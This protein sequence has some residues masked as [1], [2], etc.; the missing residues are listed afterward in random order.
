MKKKRKLKTK[1]LLIFITCIIFIT[2]SICYGMSL[3]NNTKKQKKVNKTKENIKLNKL[4]NIDQ[5]IDYF[6]YDYIDRYIAYQ[7]ENKD[8][9]I[10]QIITEVNIGLD[11]PYYTNTKKAK[12]LN[13][14]QILVNKYNYLTEDYIP[15]NLE[16]IN[17]E[18]S[19]S[20]MKLI[21]YAKEAFEELA[22]AAKKENMTIIAMSSYRS[23]IYQENLYNKYVSTDG[24]EAADTYSA[25]PGYSEHQT[26]LAVDVYNGDLPYT[27]FEQTEE[28]EWMQENA[29]K[30]GFILR[31]PKDKTKQ[32]G[33]QYESW[34]YRYVG[35][36]IAKYIHK[37]NIC[38][39]EYYAQ[40]LDKK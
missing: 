39:E 22:Q 27:S 20:G 12:D 35:K 33:Y 16:D 24:K 3:T 13:E 25:R 19:R 6:N 1:N 2:T 28:F 14:P 32:T 40:H 21:N 18:Y 23:Y 36:E 8:L 17:T 5:K 4:E 37:N 9:E 29:Y 30:Y 10:T 31:F 11:N 15:E 7:K 38:Y 34:H 26:G